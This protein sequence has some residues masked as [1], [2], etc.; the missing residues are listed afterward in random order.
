MVQEEQMASASVD[1]GKSVRTDSRRLSDRPEMIP[2]K[3]QTGRLLEQALSDQESNLPA[4]PQS[5]AGVL[6]RGDPDT[7]RS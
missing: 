5:S 4:V 3:C 1:A 6:P 2:L 7:S